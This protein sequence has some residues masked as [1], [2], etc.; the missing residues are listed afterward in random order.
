M[1]W[2][3]NNDQGRHRGLAL[4]VY[5]PPAPGHRQV[6]GLAAELEMTSAELAYQH[7][8]LARSNRSLFR[9]FYRKRIASIKA[10]INGLATAEQTLKDWQ[11]ATHVDVDF[12]AIGASRTSWGAADWQHEKFT[13]RAKPE[14]VVN[15]ELARINTG[16][17]NL[18]RWS[19]R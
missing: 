8:E 19:P 17:S 1:G 18:V 2:R 4:T 3:V 9:W 10:A 5:V 16:S 6:Q 15:R 13:A 12:K 14:W 11:P 7:A